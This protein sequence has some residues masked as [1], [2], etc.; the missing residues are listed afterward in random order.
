MFVTEY[1]CNGNK[2]CDKK[3]NRMFFSILFL[4]SLTRGRKQCHITNMNTVQIASNGT[5]QNINQDV[6]D[7]Y[8]KTRFYGTPHPIFIPPGSQ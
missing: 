1:G 6:Q 4:F 5:W 2:T 8:L 3:R 7:Q